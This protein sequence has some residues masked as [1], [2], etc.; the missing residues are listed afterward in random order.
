M[1]EAIHNEVDKLLKEGFIR[2][3]NYP[4][5]VLNVVIVKKANGKL[6]MCVDFTDLNKICHKDSFTLS[7][8]HQLVDST[9]SH[10]L[11]S[12]MD[13]FSGYN[14][15]YMSSSDKEKQLL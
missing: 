2:E 14:H 15:I 6:R 12:F 4:Q 10:G 7:K 9:A 11:M 13:S 8:I 3:V 1:Y 5:W